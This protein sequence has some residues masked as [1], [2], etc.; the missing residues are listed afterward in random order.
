MNQY[1]MLGVRLGLLA[2][3]L[4]AWNYPTGAAT[5][6]PLPIEPTGVVQTLPERYPDSWFLVHDAAF[7]HMLDGKVVIL[8]ASADTVADQVKGS[9]G[10]SFIG[11]V[12]ESAAR[13]EIYVIET[14][15]SRGARG[16]RTDVMT[17][18]DRAT[19]APLGE[20]VWPTPK[21]LMSMPVRA[22][23]NTIDAGRLLLVANFNP[24]TSV[25]V[26]DLDKREILNEIATP[27]CVL[28]YPTGR[29]GF[30]SL[31]S[32]G[33]FMSVQLSTSGEVTKQ[34]RGEPF[35]SS[36]D[37]P[38]FEHAAFIGDTAYFP[39]FAGEVHPVDLG[40]S[41]ASPGKAWSLVSD[42]EREQ[43]WRP[44]G[45][46]IIDEDELGRFYVLMHPEGG[47][48]S[49][50]GGG[51]EVWVFDAEKKK[52]VLR[53]ALQEWG[54]SLAVSRGQNPLLMVT[55]PVDMS[56]EI[57]NARSGDFQRKIVGVGLETP[58]MLYGAR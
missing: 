22:A 31:C 38:I 47:D 30:S 58:L 10:A 16:D 44:G 17:I 48:G 2:S 28:A 25:T 26:I 27:G 39:S 55:N 20:I 57:Y 5:P 50:N 3:L 45:I 53:I 49:Q 15:H 7:F 6:P 13:S 42:E 43:G 41:V 23:I 32:D 21:R 1:N 9:L 24:A 11:H 37:S 56:L 34:L 19:L 8:D 36:D 46:G 12:H 4:C 51:A 33:R 29:R 35:F 14:F 18:W 52:R 54:L 40:G